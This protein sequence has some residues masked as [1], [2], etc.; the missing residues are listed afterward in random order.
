V[1][2]EPLRCPAIAS[3]LHHDIKHNAVLVDGAPEKV[4]HTPDTN[5]YFIE[6]PLVTRPG[7][8]PTQVIGEARTELQAPL[9]DALIGALSR[10]CTLTAA[11]YD[12][13]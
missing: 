5:E 13:R 9:P 4:K 12:R 7:S 10:I 3:A 8:P 11:M 6:M 2:E 1:P